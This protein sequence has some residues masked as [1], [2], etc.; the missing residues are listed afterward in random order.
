M[1]IKELYS[2]AVL[3]TKYVAQEPLSHKKRDII[4][5]IIAEVLL[6]LR[7][8]FAPSSDENDIPL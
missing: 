7:S 8:T 3:L 2:L 1:T 4:H 5:E 6:S